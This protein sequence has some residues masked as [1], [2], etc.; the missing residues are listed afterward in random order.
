[1]KGI[2]NRM[3]I[4]LTESDVR[5]EI[6]RIQKFLKSSMRGFEK[7][8]IGISGGLDCDVVARLAQRVVG[9]NHLKLF[10]VI[11]EDMDT[12]HI[13]NARLLAEDLDTELIEFQLMQVP[14]D[15]MKQIA[16]A[17]KRENFIPDG[18]DAMRMKCNLRTS[19]YSSYQDHEYIVLGTSNKTEYT[20]GFYMPFG[21]GICHIKPIVHLYKSQVIELAKQLGTREEV[22]KQP[23]SAGF[24][25]GEE[26]I[27]DLA[28]WLYNKG[29]IKQEIESTEENIP[30]V[31]AI[32]AQ[33]S[34]EK[35]DMVLDGILNGYSDESISEETG[36]SLSIIE[37]FH[38]LME[39]AAKFKHMPLNVSLSNYTK[40]VL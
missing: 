39:G 40:E 20:T 14:F 35:I 27:D 31:E 9:S 13:R 36:I 37:L 38:L 1:M 4:C 15:M 30:K 34:V 26:D 28:W 25:K 19:I 5:V 16:E 22:I 8:V 11:Q 2:D 17:D 23:G 6:E 12:E 29:P 33:L 10:T 24:W 7:V 18:L 21:D 3:S 32:K